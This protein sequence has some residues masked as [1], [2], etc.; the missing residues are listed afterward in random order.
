MK[1]YVIMGNDFPECVFDT[2]EKA[3]AF[4]TERKKLDEAERKT[5]GYGRRIY[6][7]VYE[8]EVQK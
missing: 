6:W 7:R 5:P 4:C 2:E 3:E 1:V 8:F